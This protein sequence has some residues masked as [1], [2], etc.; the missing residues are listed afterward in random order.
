MNLTYEHHFDIRKNTRSPFKHARTYG[1]TSDVYNWHKNI[2]ILLITGG[3]GVVRYGANEL[4]AHMGDLFVINRDAFHQVKSDTG[5]DFSYMIIDETFCNENGISTEDFL[6][7]QRFRDSVSQSLYLAAAEKI[8]A[9]SVASTPIAI[10]HTRAAVLLFLIH[11]CEEHAESRASKSKEN[12]I[13]EEYVKKTVSFLDEHFAEAHTLSSLSA[14]LGITPHHLARVFKQ[15]TGETVFSH[16][17]RLRCRHAKSA[18]LDGATVTE[19]A[20]LS[21]FASL[22]YFS[23]TYKRIFGETPSQVKKT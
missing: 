11:L 4:P 23:R 22:P 12:A 2:E 1:E 6:F 9:L 15:Y 18:L 14:L 19:A 16:M 5:I 8:D 10:A 3:E 21:G 17:N 20:F 7:E 13:G